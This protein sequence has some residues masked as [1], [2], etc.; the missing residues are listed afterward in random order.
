MNLDLINMKIKNRINELIAII[1]ENYN[2]V[3]GALH[4]VIDNHNLDDDD[5]NWCINNSISNIKDN[6][7]RQIYLECAK[8]LLKLS[9]SSRCRLI[10]HDNKRYKK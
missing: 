5:I 4:L 10:I 7:E 1:Y 9:Y 6:K 3:G 8:L 2:C